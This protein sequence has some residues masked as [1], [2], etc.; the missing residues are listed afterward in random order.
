MLLFTV[1]YYCRHDY[2]KSSACVSD[3]SYLD[4]R[5]NINYLIKQHALILTC[6]M[7]IYA[8]LFSK[9]YRRTTHV[10]YRLSVRSP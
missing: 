4:R 9:V 7:Y 6:F 5:V 10:L 8:L 3:R 2:L 1:D